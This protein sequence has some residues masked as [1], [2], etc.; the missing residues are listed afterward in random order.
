[1]DKYAF[2][3]KNITF[4]YPVSEPVLRGLTLRIRSGE[5]LC[6][7]G[8]NGCGKST[9]LR[10]LGG[11]LIPQEGSFYFYGSMID[12]RSITKKDAADY[13][14]RVGYVF[15][16]SDV[17]LFC[18]SVLEEIAFGPLQTGLPREEIMDRVTSL[19]RSLDIEKLLDKAPYHLSGGEKKKVA[20]ASTLILDP[21]VLILDEPT[22]DLDPRSQTW[23]LKL[24]KDLRNQGKTLIF[25]THNLEL[26]P[27]VADRAILFA[28]DH[29][30]RADKPV[31]ELLE[32]TALLR[33]VNLVDEHFHTHP[34]DFE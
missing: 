2:E 13:H 24:L 19:A 21:D 29:T 22:N 12:W 31:R 7:L 15:Q 9:L 11:L 3:L 1:M 26:V 20:I 32:D 8:A 33:E 17:Q 6:I 25:A 14:L 27:H 10:I 18:G 4:S 5:S 23:L 28:E 30:L 16:D 34:W